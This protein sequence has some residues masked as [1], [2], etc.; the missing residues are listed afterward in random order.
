VIAEDKLI[1]WLCIYRN[2]TDS[3]TGPLMVPHAVREAWQGRGWVTED[4][5]GEADWQ[6]VRWFTLTEAGDDACDL[7]SSEWAIDC[8][9]N[10]TA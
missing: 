7:N 3:E 2:Q 10:E 1:G 4:N 6:G 5:A 8:I 9:P